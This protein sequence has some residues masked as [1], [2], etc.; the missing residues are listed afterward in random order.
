MQR[1]QCSNDLLGAGSCKWSETGNAPQ[2]LQK[3]SLQLFSPRWDQILVTLSRL[4]H[5]AFTLPQ[6]DHTTL[7]AVLPTPAKHKRRTVGR[8]NDHPSREFELTFPKLIELMIAPFAFIQ[9]MNIVVRFRFGLYWRGA[10]Y[11]RMSKP[12]AFNL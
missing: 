4:Q 7:L 1:L 2:L 3:R 5:R 8:S 11:C 12:P 9:L 6:P 10:K